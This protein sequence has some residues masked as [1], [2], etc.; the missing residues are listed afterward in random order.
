MNI[1]Q[2]A[3][4]VRMSTKELRQALP[5]IGFDLGG[6]AIKVDSKVAQAI[7]YK[8]NNKAVRDK[9][10]HEIEAIENNN[11]KEEPKPDELEQVSG[12]RVLKIDSEIV[13]KDLAKKI[14]VDVTKLVV[15]LMKQGIMASLND[16][17]DFDTACIVAEDFGFKVEMNDKDTIDEDNTNKFKGL[18]SEQDSKNSI[19]RPP[20]VV[21]MGHVDHGKTKLLDTIRQT[22]VVDEESGGITQ[23]I[24]AYQ[25]EKEGQKITFIDTPGHEA[26]SMMR[27]RGA[28]IADLAILVVA[29][30]DGV[31]PQTIEAISHIRNANLPF[32]VAVNKIDKPEANQDKVKS[33]LAELG[34]TSEDWGGK[35]II[36]PISA[37]SGE[38]IHSLL[39]SLLL[40]Y[41]MEKENITADKSGLPI[42][43]VIE[44]HID[45]GVGSVATVLVMNGT[46]KKGL[47][48]SIGGSLGKLR[49][50]KDWKGEEIKEASPA[51][52]VAVLGLGGVPQVGEI[53]KGLGSTAEIRHARRVKKS[54]TIVIEKQ[55]IK[56]S[57]K[58]NDGV[59]FINLMIKAD[60]LGSLEALDE[61]FEKIENQGIKIN[62][63]SRG[64]GNINESDVL[65]AEDTNSLLLGFSI[66]T[67]PESEVIAR[68]KG[69]TLKVFDI[70]YDLLDFVASEATSKLSPVINRI[71]LGE[72]KVLK[73]FRVED[74]FIVL[75][76]AVVLG[77][78]KKES[79][80]EW[81]SQG[82]VKAHGN[83]QELQSG[84]EEVSEVVE[85]QQAGLRVDN[86]GDIQPGDMLNF[87]EEQEKIKKI[88]S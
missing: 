44:S 58:N 32:I 40:I 63:V 20:I 12:S 36:V 27:S 71:N 81:L 14:G 41:E 65:R 39:E 18:L 15:E 9:V 86:I 79:K 74:K 45:K 56:S 42:G 54:K 2:L 16:R 19:H 6:R 1:T 5:L 50:M 53:L 78:I 73:L 46:L 87:F 8:L 62:V 61:S 38:N 13:V 31:Q 3:R 72:L 77:K 30:D 11:L 55:G 51:T 35:T 33:E 4:Q 24:G 70:I 17:I 75:G 29:A 26:F 48:V 43:V 88:I 25:V 84:K 23:H 22:N 69:I 66:R 37:K 49:V 83:I 80:F 10:H 82:K 47:S 76:G 85:G 68:S 59:E 28:K 52:P 21:V 60:V 57:I 67:S 64:L 34:L 7:I